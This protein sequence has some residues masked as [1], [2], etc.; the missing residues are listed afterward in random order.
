MSSCGLKIANSFR[1]L[2]LLK[3]GEAVG[4][5]EENG[6]SVLEIILGNCTLLAIH[7]TQW[8]HQAILQI[9]GD[10]TYRYKLQYFCA[11]AY[12][13]ITRHTSTFSE[14]RRERFLICNRK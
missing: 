9:G 3:Q 2:L 4:H 1:S 14:A 12:H 5:C 10:F 6:I 11:H 8:K 7:P 13:A